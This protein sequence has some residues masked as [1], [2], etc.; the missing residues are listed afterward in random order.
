MHGAAKIGSKGR[1]Y[2]SERSPL[3]DALDPDFN[4][5]IDEAI[6]LNLFPDISNDSISG[7]V[8]GDFDLPLDDAVAMDH[9]QMDVEM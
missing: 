3:G 4:F 2:L 8:G 1:G 9:G 7:P 6:D 5:P